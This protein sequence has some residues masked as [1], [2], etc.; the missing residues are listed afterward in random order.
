[1]RYCGSAATNGYLFG[2]VAALYVGGMQPA[3]YK[4]NPGVEY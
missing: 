2:F 3:T 1:M 4:L